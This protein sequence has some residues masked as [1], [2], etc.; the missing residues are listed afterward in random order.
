MF[1][2]SPLRYW[3]IS[4]PNMGTSKNALHKAGPC[5]RLIGELVQAPPSLFRFQLPAKAPGTQWRLA[6]VLGSCH[7]CR[8]P[9][10][11]SQL[12]PGTA[13]AVV[14]LWRVNQQMEM[15]SPSLSSAFQINK[16]DKKNIQE[17]VSHKRSSL[18]GWQNFS[19]RTLGGVNEYVV[20]GAVLLFQLC[21][22]RS[23]PLLC[24]AYPQNA[25]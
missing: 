18:D 7:L 23:T 8:R 4:F 10:W 12:W 25:S 9:G 5:A 17:C 3:F 24:S 1:S 11:S 22:L 6:Q 14:A 20:V 19:W 2:P 21:C 16:Y 15:R 13:L